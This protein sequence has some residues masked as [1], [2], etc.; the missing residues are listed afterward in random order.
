MQPETKTSELGDRIDAFAKSKE[1]DEF[2]R[3]AINRDIE[4]L[5]KADSASASAFRGMMAALDRDEQATRR[6]F[7]NARR[8]RPHDRWIEFH[9]SKA[10]HYLGYF[11]ESREMVRAICESDRSNLA[12]LDEL[13]RQTIVSGRAIEAAELMARRNLLKPDDQHT[14]QDSIQSFSAF[15]QRHD[16]QDNDV[17]DLLEVTLNLLHDAGYYHDLAD[18][19]V[20]RDGESEWFSGRLEVAGPVETIVELNVKLA[21]TQAAS[22]FSPDLMTLVN[23]LFVP[24][25]N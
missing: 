25:S 11:R 6:H 1:R 2:T 15:Y 7:E 24:A 20:R 5:Q 21:D 9:Y 18:Y 13:I 12:M 14:Y 16:V 17:E 22:E 3:T 4:T 8:L 10:L 19:G 23:F